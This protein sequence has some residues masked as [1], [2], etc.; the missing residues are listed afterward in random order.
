[1][2]EL[3]LQKA[4]SELQSDIAPPAGGWQKIR[5]RLRS[6]QRRWLIPAAAA[7]SLAAFLLALNVWQLDDPMVVPG[8]QGQ[9]DGQ[10]AVTETSASD[11][12]LQ[13]TAA[14]S[15]LVL[16]FAAAKRAIAQQ[17]NAGEVVINEQTDKGVTEGLQALDDAVK[18]I[19][20][21]LSEQP[22]SVYLSDLLAST[23]RRQIALMRQLVLRSAA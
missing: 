8:E 2:D 14:E 23:Q 1:M 4:L 10:L 3:H 13:F 11:D 17:T 21:A 18:A 12:Q 20:L 16:E 22:D 5:S 15:V 6:R 19:R 9:V 7:A